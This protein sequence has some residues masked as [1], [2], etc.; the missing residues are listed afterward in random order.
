MR[1]L[2]V[3]G[4]LV[5]VMTSAPATASTDCPQHFAGGVAPSFTNPKLA[6]RSQELCYSGFA[7]MNS[8]LSRTGLWSAEY[9]TRER[10]AAAKGDERKNTFH[11]DEN[12]A[13]NDR[14][15]LS[16]YKGSGYDRG[17][18]APSADMPDPQ[19]MH[20]SFSLANMIP[21]VAENNRGI[22]AEIEKTTRNYA[23]KT[24]E[25]YV[26]TGPL[27]YG[28]NVQQLKGRVLIPTHI[29]KVVY[30]PKANLAG[31]YVVSNTEPSAEWQEV[32]VSE[33]E[34]ISGLNLL[35]AVP[36]AVKARAIDLP[37]P[38]TDKLAKSLQRSQKEP[39]AP[40]PDALIDG[41]MRA[42]QLMRRGT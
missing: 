37:D 7:V 33:I 31:A 19:S 15:R 6:P 13:P 2:A 1:M 28:E 38:R 29:F 8:G 9:L 42:L 16:D 14:A 26:I 10:I 35:P 39:A 25:L 40:Q 23:Q 41:A 36:E 21:Q 4:L 20:E 5:G 27:F 24:G 3:L 32:A 34:K 30:D 12:L 18:L 17:H 22:W 11:E